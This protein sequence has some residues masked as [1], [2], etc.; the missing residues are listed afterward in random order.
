EPDVEIY[1]FGGC[2]LEERI[3]VMPWPELVDADAEPLREALVHCALVR[4]PR[5]LRTGHD[6]VEDRK[7][8]ALVEVVELE[9]HGVEAR[10][11][12][13]AGRRVALACKLAE[14]VLYLGAD[15]LRRLPRPAAQIEVVGLLEDLA[16][17]VLAHAR[18]VEICAEGVEPV[19]E[20][21]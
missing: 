21:R 18:A 3:R 19:L 16:N 13:L 12:D 14:L 20:R 10:P 17:V 8:V 5:C 1:A 9:R 6:P 11:A 2:F 4:I 7:N 15:L